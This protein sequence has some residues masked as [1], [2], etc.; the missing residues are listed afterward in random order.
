MDDD[1]NEVLDS[2]LDAL[3]F[4]HI[5][6]HVPSD[7]RVGIFGTAYWS[8][9]A[10]PRTIYPDVD[11]RLPV[12]SRDLGGLTMN[13][14]FGRHGGVRVTNRRGDDVEGAGVWINGTFEPDPPA[15]S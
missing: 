14:T 13:V 4:N 6:K 12:L 2:A 3:L 1:L 7:D 5:V 10:A 8:G 11:H 15:D 9:A